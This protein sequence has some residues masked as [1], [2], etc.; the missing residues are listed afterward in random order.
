MKKP[1]I[2]TIKRIDFLEIA[3]YLKR[4]HDVNIRPIMDYFEAN[5]GTDFHIE[6]DDDLE[7]YEE[8]AEELKA[9]KKFMLTLTDNPSD[10]AYHVFW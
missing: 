7:Y 9:L 2:Y 4:E 10:V 3:S 5:N 1:E 8:I 6:F